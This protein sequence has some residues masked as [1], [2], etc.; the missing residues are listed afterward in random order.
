MI[1]RRLWNGNNS[2]SDGIER[3][4]GARDNKER[5][6]D[7][8]NNYED[9]CGNDSVNYKNSPKDDDDDDWYY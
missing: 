8:V 6:H 1:D 9:D 5:N 4:V 7:A 3:D 2:F